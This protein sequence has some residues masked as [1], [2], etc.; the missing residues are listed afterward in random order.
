VGCS[1]REFGNLGGGISR[2]SRGSYPELDGDSDT[3]GGV[4]GSGMSDGEWV[5][6]GAHEVDDV[7]VVVKHLREAFP[8]ST[9][10]LWGRSMGAVTA[11]MYSQRDPSIAGVVSSSLLESPL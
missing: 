5:T 7:D 8:E 2:D 1:Q 9:I 6:L 3:E 11:L 4:Q 10:G